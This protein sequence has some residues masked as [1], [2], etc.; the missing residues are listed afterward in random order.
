MKFTYVITTHS[1]AQDKLQSTL[2]TWAS[3]VKNIVLLDDRY[4]DDLNLNDYKH[5]YL[6]M[7]KFFKECD[8]SSDF[9]VCSCD[10]TFVMTEKLENVLSNT[11]EDGPCMWAHAIDNAIRTGAFSVFNKEAMLVLKQSDLSLLTHPE[12]TCLYHLC[13]HLGIK[14]IDTKATFMSRSATV[15]QM[16]RGEMCGIHPCTIEEQH[17]LS[18]ILV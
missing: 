9:Y 18:V 13:K 14:I 10:D 2:E 5:V 17:E 4:H 1:G 6:K 3:G 12:D 11:T 7:R 16:L 15:D 8:C